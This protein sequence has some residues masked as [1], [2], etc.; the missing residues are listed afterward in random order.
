MVTVWEY[1]NSYPSPLLNNVF[2][3]FYVESGESSGPDLNCAGSLSW[4]DLDPE[5]VVNGSF[6]V[7]NIGGSGSLL[8]W[9]IESY[10]DW[11]TWTFTPESGEDVAPED[12]SVVIGVTVVAPDQYNTE[13]TGEIRI[14]NKEDSDDFDVVPVSLSTPVNQNVLGEMYLQFMLKSSIMFKSE[15]GL[16]RVS[17]L[18]KGRYENEI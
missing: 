7:Q 4:N 1:V 11:G 9:E 6:T 17:S 2:K 3:I 10:P 15:V 12:G 8:D 14:V 16:E 13:F 5:D 18:L